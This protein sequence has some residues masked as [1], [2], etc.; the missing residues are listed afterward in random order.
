MKP[1]FIAIFLTCFQYTLFAQQLFNNNWQ[2]H[3]GDMANPQDTAG[4]RAVTLPHD[5]SIEGPFDEQWA[6]ATA[7]LPAGIGWYKKE[8]TAGKDWQGKHVFI[9]FDG[10]YKNST[11]WLNGHLLGNRPN[12][13]IAFEYELTPYLNLTG[14]NTLTVKVDHTEFADS[15]WYTGSGIYRNVYL[16]VKNPV[17]ITKWGVQFSTPVIS[18]A[19]A[20]ANTRVTVKN[21]SNK[22]ASVTVQCSLTDDKGAVVAKANNQLSLNAVDSVVALLSFN[23]NNP[24]LWSVD[25]PSL[26]L[27][28]VTVMANGKTVDRYTE[29]VGIRQLRFDAN[30]GFFLNNKNIKLKGVCIHDDAGSLGVAVP[31]GVWRSR[32]Q[33]LKELGC[34]SLRFSHNP[35]ADY[36]YTLSDEMGFLVIDEAFDEWEI[37]KNKWIKGWN[38]G[39]PGNDGYH[40]YFKE[41]ANIDVRDMILR[42]YN[43]PGIIAWSIGNEIDYPN[44]P[45]TDKVL[46]SGNNP[47]IYG[48]GFLPGHPAAS[49][50]GEISKQL[51]NVV[52][53]YDTT[54]PVTAALAGVVMSNKTTYP[55]NLDWVGYNYQEYR[56]AGD[57]QLYPNRIIYG[58]ENGM[59][60][61]AWDAVDSNQYI[62][63][64]YLW[65]GIDYMGE[66]G[67]WPGKGSGAGLIDMA[68]FTKPEYYFRQSL[69]SD[70][71]MVFIGATK[72]PNEDSKNIWRHLRA[73]PTWNWN[74]GDSLWVN[75]Y[76]NCDEAELFLNGRSL[77][78]KKLADFDNRIIT[79]K[80]IYA[81]GKLEVTGYNKGKQAAHY[82]LQTAGAPA[83]LKATVEKDRSGLVQVAIHI[84]DTNGLLVNKAD[85]EIQVTTQGAVLLGLE[86]GSISSHEDNKG[87]T[88]KA[89]N[90][91]LKAFVMKNHAAQ[92]ASITI[93]S[94]GLPAVTIKL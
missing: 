44:D 52:K 86:S 3:K 27:L 8:F 50:L 12:G 79:W 45:Y 13:F 58:S 26:Y 28:S 25:N 93:A 62:S 76:T 23:I 19:R 77:G 55:D 21:A 59:A 24:V 90:G 33:T 89:V 31:E 72:A 51:R 64:Q 57:H 5:W 83:A 7:F 70:K 49:R 16:K 68:G 40:A 73:E 15:R 92:P 94:Q 71:P 63:A 29:K 39:K 22:Q 69:W 54:R 46:D 88:R 56:Y 67:K 82:Q 61:K 75:C 87:N 48:K 42:S 30:Q 43:H 41:W 47:Q 91:R 85:N 20:V 11:V 38:V 10:V 4:W 14:K 84:E 6:S 9:Y 78:R 60:V 17:Y 35:H 36:M 1:V 65:T 18:A 53:Q 34:N 66:A 81:Q 37:G 2:F 80:V 74:T 32:L